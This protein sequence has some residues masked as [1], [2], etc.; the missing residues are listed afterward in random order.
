RKVGF[1]GNTRQGST[2]VSGMDIYNW[3]PGAIAK[4]D[5]PLRDWFD[6]S[7]EQKSVYATARLNLAD[8]LKLILGA[9]LDWFDYEDTSYGYANFDA[10]IPSSITRN[11]YA[12]TRNVTK[13]AGLVYDVDNQ[14]SVY[15]SYTDIFK[16]QSYLDADRT[17]LAPIKGKNYE[18]GIKG[19]YFEGA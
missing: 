9:R 2:L 10:N 1:D 18:I 16:P 17:V 13:Y 12:I 5:I 11:Q 8:R 7:I 6:S 14:H 4:P 15:A 3:D 19:E